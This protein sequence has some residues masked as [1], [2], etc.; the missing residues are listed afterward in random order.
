MLDKPTNCHRLAW[1]MAWHGCNGSSIGMGWVQW[2]KHWHGLGAMAQALAWVGCNGSSIGMGWVQWL[3]H[4]HQ[5]NTAN[6]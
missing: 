4:W 1:V 6:G 5:A 2:L 3:K